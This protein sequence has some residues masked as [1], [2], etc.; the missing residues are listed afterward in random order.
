M[1]AAKEVSIASNIDV[2]I[3]I[4]LCVR[5]NSRFEVKGM[6]DTVGKRPLFENT[7]A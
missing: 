2:C 5:G 3:E 1:L 7:K 6:S 4:H